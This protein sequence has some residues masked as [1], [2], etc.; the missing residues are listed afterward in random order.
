M[1]IDKQELK[2]LMLDNTPLDFCRLYLF[3]QE[4]YLFEKAKEFEIKGT[5]HELKCVIANLLDTSPNNVAIVGSGKFGFSMNPTNSELLKEFNPKSDLDIV[6]ACPQIFEKTWLNLRKSF[7]S[8]QNSVREKHA[9][10]VFSKYIVVNNKMQYN[11]DYMR[12]TITLLDD[13]KKII[14]RQFRI[15]RTIN[16]RIYSSWSDVEAYHEFGI[17]HLQHALETGRGKDI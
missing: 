8:N 10:D 7:Y 5:Y 15:K 9:N 16:Y 4:I 14:S 13:M 6:I 1:A 2:R 3:D 11:S 12:A 17:S